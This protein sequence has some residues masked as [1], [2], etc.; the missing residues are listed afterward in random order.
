MSPMGS[1]SDGL[2]VSALLPLHPPKADIHREVRQSVWC[3]KADLSL[4]RS[5]YIREIGG[6]IR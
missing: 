5:L 3:Q 2:S 1:K 6:S 4:R